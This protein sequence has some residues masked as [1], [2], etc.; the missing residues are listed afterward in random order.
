MSEYNVYKDVKGFLARVDSAIAVYHIYK[1]GLEEEAAVH[2][3][4]FEEDKVKFQELYLVNVEKATEAHKV[5]RGVNVTREEHSYEDKVYLGLLYRRVPIFKE[6]VEEVVEYQPYDKISLCVDPTLA[7]L[8]DLSLNSHNKSLFNS[9][10]YYPLWELIEDLWS[11]EYEQSKKRLEQL[12]CKF[13]SVNKVRKQFIGQEPYI[14]VHKDDVY[15]INDL[16]E[17]TY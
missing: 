10:I 16:L 2:K 8:P 4:K 9:T 12:E 15:A 17:Y 5:I 6:V 11:P 3:K 14:K 7:E 13:S 1:E